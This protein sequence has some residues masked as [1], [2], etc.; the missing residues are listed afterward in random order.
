MT[1]TVVYVD[2]VDRCGSKFPIFSAVMDGGDVLSSVRS[3]S[4][5]C[6]RRRHFGRRHFAAHCSNIER[7]GGGAFAR[8]HTIAVAAGPPKVAASAPVRPKFRARRRPRTSATHVGHD[9]ERAIERL[10]GGGGGRLWREP[11]YS[12]T[13]KEWRHSII[14]YVVGGGGGEVIR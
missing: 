4:A 12:V 14:I 9:R 3:V 5:R 7:P 2:C 11:P 6:T 13:G 1:S 10:G 8:A